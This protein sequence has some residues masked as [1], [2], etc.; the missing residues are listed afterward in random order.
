[1]TRCAVKIDYACSTII[2]DI[3][4]NFVHFPHVRR[5]LSTLDRMYE[6]RCSIEEAE[7]I[8]IVGESGV[9]KSTLLEWYSM[10]HPVIE[11]DEL[12]EVP[13]LYVPLGQS[14]TPKIMANTLL[15]ALGDPKWHVGKEVE[16]TARLV[17]LI[18]QC[19]VRVV[20]IDEANHLIDRGGEKTLHTAADWL[21]RL[22]DATRISFVLAGI[23]RTTRLLQ[24]NDQLRGRF[25]EVIEIDRFSVANTS[26]EREFRSVLKVFKGYLRDLPSIDISGTAITRLFAFATDGRLRDI[27]RLMVRAVELAY[28]SSSPSLTDTVLAEAFRTAIY[29]GSPDNRNPFHKAFNEMPLVK[30]DEPYA[31]VR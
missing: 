17:F 5:I 3:R 29:P 26:A 28:E 20:I 22:V 14:P 24:T 25:R 10:K 16:L 21:K 13:V 1:M 6:Y 19:R 12:T 30:A 2:K 15:R 7:N 8:V 11:H 18:R 27:R 23:P 4:S 31:S 9:G